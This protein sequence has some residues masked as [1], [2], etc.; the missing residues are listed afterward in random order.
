MTLNQSWH[1]MIKVP[2]GDIPDVLAAVMRD[3]L[4]NADILSLVRHATA[5]AK[6]YLRLRY[7]QY[8]PRF[9]D[10]GYSLHDVAIRCITILFLPD[11][12]SLCP[13]IRNGLATI[14]QSNAHP[15]ADDFTRAFRALVTQSVENSVPQVLGELDPWYKKVLRNVSDHIHE[16]ACHSMQ[17]FHETLIHRAAVEELHCELPE[18]PAESLLADLFDLHP[19]SDSAADLIEHIFDILDGQTSHRRILPLSVIVRTL[20]DYFVLRFEMEESDEMH[21]EATMIRNDLLALVP[22]I[23]QEGVDTVLHGYLMR[24]EITT[25]QAACFTEAAHQYLRE[26]LDGQESPVDWYFDIHFRAM[27]C[28]GDTAWRKNQLRY[29]LKVVRQLFI[30]RGRQFFS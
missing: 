8:F 9:E 13:R 27:P 22:S 5:V 3:D 28:N 21:I 29:F 19:A 6:A 26:L 25:D 23:V 14:L 17:G 30:K 18:Y 20:R 2:N 7:W 15:D 1:R 11:D 16:S 10:A 24:E 4:T 12:T